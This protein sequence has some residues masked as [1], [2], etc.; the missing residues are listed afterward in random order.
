MQEN[1][2]GLLTKE[3]KPKPAWHEYANQVKQ[4]S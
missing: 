2:F 3:R 1:H 4:R